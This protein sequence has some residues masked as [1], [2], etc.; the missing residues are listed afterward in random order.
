MPFYVFLYQRQI[1]LASGSSFKRFLDLVENFDILVQ[2][3]G[4]PE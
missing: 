1:R 2:F 3:A 4:K